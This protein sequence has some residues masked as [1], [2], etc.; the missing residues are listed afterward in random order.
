LNNT[1]L[2]TALTLNQKITL[3]ITSLAHGGSGV[4]RYQD[5]VIFVPFTC[6]EDEVQVEITSLKKNYGEGRLVN[7]ITAS[8]HRTPPPCPVFGQC[9]GCQW[10]HIRYEEQLKQKQGIIESA[11]KRTARE[12]GIEIRPIIPSP[13]VLHYRNRSEFQIEGSKIGFF[14]RGSHSLVEFD[15]C[16]IADQK[17]NLELKKLKGTGYLFSKKVKIYLNQD[18]MVRSL[19]LNSPGEDLGFSQVNTLQ[20]KNIQ[21]YLIKELSKPQKHNGQILDLYCGQ[22]NFSFP[23]NDLGWRVRGVDSNAQGIQV[24]N[25]AGRSGVTFSVGDVSCEVKKLLKKKEVFDV[26]LMD[27]PRTG[28]DKNLLPLIHELQPETLIYISCNPTTFARDWERFKKI[29]Q[30]KIHTLQP[31][32]MF[33]QTFHVELVAIAKK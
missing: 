10:Q 12:E 24:A 26:I 22:G 3:N 29:S 9:G 6:P 18:E 19:N 4:G 25:K 7:I 17:I 1:K 21:D 20:N 15:Q 14:E 30:Y 31:F 8:P 13:K 28:V 27:P 33:P 16:Y 2:S 5:F 23:L 11:L 32:D